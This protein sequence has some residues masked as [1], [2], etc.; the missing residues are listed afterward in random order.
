MGSGGGSS[1][2]SQQT[3][4]QSN[5]PDY[6][7]PQF[8]SLINQGYAQMA[9]PYQAYQ[10]QQVAGFDPMQQAA[11]GAMTNM[12]AIPGAADTA[13]QMATN[14]GN[15][16]MGAPQVG[17][18]NWTSPGVA[19]QYMSPYVQNVLDAQKA[20][21]NVD[22]QQQRN[23]M[24]DQAAAAGAYGG[25]RQAIQDAALN[26]T[27]NQQLQQMESQGLNNAYTQGQN[28]FLG[29][30]GQS[31]QAQQANQGNYMQGLQAQLGASG[32]L[33]QLAPAE[34][35]MAMN[36]ING[37]NT[38]GGQAQQ[39]QQALLGTAQNQWNQGQN[40][41]WQQLGNYGNLLHGVPVG[42]TYTNTTY[43]PAPSLT[44]GIGGLATAGMGAFMGG[45][46][47][48]GAG[49]GAATSD[50]RLKKDI[51][52]LEVDD[53]GLTLYAFRYLWEITAPGREKHVGYMAQEVQQLYPEAIIEGAD[54]YFAVDYAKIPATL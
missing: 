49:G 31:L 42:Q 28:T 9:T 8:T 17:V 4:T 12:Q 53:N 21:M 33:G 16:S 44:S 41:N 34:Q 35:Q 11:M 6:V 52:K 45:G 26:R 25:D 2:P 29:S 38:M 22:Y 51:E 14:V 5:L 47:G 24:N 10:G 43:T 36:W 15:M 50:R 46:S 30:Q 27:Y 37:M 23:Q 20:N 54:G 32:Q 39:Q 19:Q 18:Q 40:W 1:G 7:S 3:V 48:G 13:G